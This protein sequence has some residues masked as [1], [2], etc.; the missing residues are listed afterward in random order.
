[1]VILESDNGSVKTYKGL[2]ITSNARLKF[3]E[4]SCVACGFCIPECPNNAW[5]E[6]SNTDGGSEMLSVVF[7]PN[8]C[9]MDGG[10]AEVCPMNALEFIEDDEEDCDDPSASASVSSDGLSISTISA[11]SNTRTKLYQWIIYKHDYDLWRFVS[12]EK[13]VHKKVIRNGV[14]EWQWESLTHVSID[15][16]GW[17]AL[18]SFTVT[19]VDVVSLGMYYTGIQLACT[20]HWS[21]LCKGFPVDHDWTFPTQKS[22]YVND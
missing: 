12:T 21:F 8:A 6:P 22:W 15:R 7:M 13:G 17:Y 16:D 4:W 1:M 19:A 2:G 10:C 11:M 9:N 3:E 14:S 5:L 20:A 18:A